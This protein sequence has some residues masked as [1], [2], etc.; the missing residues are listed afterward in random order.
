[1]PSGA[2]EKT[3]Q[4]MSDSLPL[5]TLSIEEV[6]NSRGQGAKKKVVVLRERLPLNYNPEVDYKS[7]SA[8]LVS[9]MSDFM[10]SLHAIRTPE[11]ACDFLSG[12]NALS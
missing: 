4:E 11:Q 6:P 8:G 1:M 3:I 7:A 2:F 9:G 12:L 5:H 10:S